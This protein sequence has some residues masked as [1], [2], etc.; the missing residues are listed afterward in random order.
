MHRLVAVAA[1]TAAAVAALGVACGGGKPPPEL[2]TSFGNEGAVDA[3]PVADAAPPEPPPPPDAPPMTAVTLPAMPPVVTRLKRG[4]RPIELRYALPAPGD[5]PA[6]IV[7]QSFE[8]AMEVT[9]VGVARRIDLPDQAVGSTLAY[10]AVGAEA[11]VPPS[12][13]LVQRMNRGLA[14]DAAMSSQFEDARGSEL[15]YTIDDRG[16][17]G[18]LRVLSRATDAAGAQQVLSI[19][20]GNGGP[21]VLPAEPVGVGG[22]WRVVERHPIAGVATEITTTYTIKARDGDRLTLAG[23]I[24]TRTP[25]YTGDGVVHH[26]A[27]GTGTLTATVDLARPA[28]EITAS[29]R[30]DAAIT[31]EGRAQRIVMTHEVRQVTRDR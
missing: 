3:A 14:A 2:P 6:Q 29:L 31:L 4:K 21:I 10:A 18:D 19:L 15:A 27:A 8:T 28:P 13:A 9:E 22:S 26:A 25:A 23:T 17:A 30:F 24:E 1:L 16:R 12:I 11:G 5:A 7:D 20:R